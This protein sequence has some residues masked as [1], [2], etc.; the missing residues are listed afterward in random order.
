MTISAATV[1]IGQFV[2]IPIQ[3]LTSNLTTREMQIW[4]LMAKFCSPEF[5]CMWIRQAA[6]AKEASC[7]INRVSKVIKSIVKKGWAV[8]LESEL[9]ECNRYKMIWTKGVSEPAKK[10]LASPGENATPPRQKRQPILEGSLDK[11]IQQQSPPPVV[12]VQK[13]EVPKVTLAEKTEEKP[14][15][16][17]DTDQKLIVRLGKVGLPKNA[18]K[19]LLKHYGAKSCQKQCDH[20]AWQIEQ[21][22][23]IKN[24]AGWLVAAIKGNYALP[25]TKEAEA[26]PDTIAQKKQKALIRE[27]KDELHFKSWRKVVNLCQEA[28]QL[29]E[30]EKATELLVFAKKRQEEELQ[31]KAKQGFMENILSR[32]GGARG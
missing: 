9:G 16:V 29:G 17:S 30:C 5:P 13:V 26:K 1:N 11:L 19:R 25:Q 18:S 23:A 31:E 2:R 6:I 28:L 12:P 10:I 14:V 7:S 4:G 3:I 22:K 21:G 24:K 15:V 32:M 20:L 27:A 8:L